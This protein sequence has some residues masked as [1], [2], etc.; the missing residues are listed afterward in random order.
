[1]W[2]TLVTSVC[3]VLG[4]AGMASAHFGMVI[5]S[6]ST[7]MDKQDASLSLE[8]SFSHPMDMRGM[9]LAEP[10]VFEVFTDGKAQNLKA[11]LQPAKLADHDAWTASG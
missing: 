11:A 7:V 1:M 8:L 9:N 3:L 4:T 2:K 5:P 6:A 10:R